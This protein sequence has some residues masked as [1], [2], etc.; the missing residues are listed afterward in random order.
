MALKKAPQLMILMLQEE[1]Q[2]LQPPPLTP[3]RLAAAS[4]LPVAFL[5]TS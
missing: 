5:C 4:E 1:A 2:T 3:V